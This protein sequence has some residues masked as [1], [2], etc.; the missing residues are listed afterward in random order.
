MSWFS[1][2][3]SSTPGSNRVDGKRARD[4]VANGAQLVDVR[5]PAEF[6]SGHVPG[7]INI[8]VHMLSSHVGQLDKAKDIVVYCRSGARSASAASALL[9]SGFNAVYD[10]GPISAW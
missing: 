7:A 6:A 9:Q 10:L 4:L 3:L 5:T 1:N 8:P 2:L